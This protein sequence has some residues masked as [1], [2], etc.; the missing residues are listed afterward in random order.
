VHHLC[1]LLDACCSILKRYAQVI[2]QIRTALRTPSRTAATK[3]SLEDAS[4]PACTA[5]TKPSEDVFEVGT[6]EDVFLCVLRIDTGMP[7]PV[8]LFPLFRIRQHPV[9]L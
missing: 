2:P 8:V 4:A 3:E 7:E 9:R 6:P 1:L 5:A